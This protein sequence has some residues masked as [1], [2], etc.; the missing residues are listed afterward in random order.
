M[1]FLIC[2]SVKQVLLCSHVL[3]SD[4]YSIADAFA[5]AIRFM[6]NYFGGLVE[7]IVWNLHRIDTMRGYLSDH[8]ISYKEVDDED[9]A[10]LHLSAS[11]TRPESYCECLFLCRLGVDVDTVNANTGATNL[12]FVVYGGLEM[13]RE[14]F[15]AKFKLLIEYG[16]SIYTFGQICR[17][18]GSG[19][20]PSRN[21]RYIP[22]RSRRYGIRPCRSD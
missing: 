21:S 22:E 11:S 15:R 8:N 20:L 4:E 2:D 10:H 14:L 17:H 5:D 12:H 6:T 13:Q 19:S 16:A 9:F 7:R 1:G 3:E 18:A